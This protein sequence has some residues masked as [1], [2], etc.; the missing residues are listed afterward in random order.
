MVHLRGH[1]LPDD[2]YEQYDLATIEDQLIEIIEQKG[3]GAFDGNEMGPKE[4][5]L[6]MYGADAERLYSSIESAL[7]NYP[8]CQ[9]A[10][11]ILRYGPPGSE[12]REILL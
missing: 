7:R 11:V 12:Q 1:G 3:L 2:V 6:F 10:K 8:L 4:T 5:I 9:G